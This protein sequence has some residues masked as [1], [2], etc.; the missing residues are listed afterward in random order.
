MSLS[1]AKYVLAVVGLAIFLGSLLVCAHTA[2]Y[3]GRAARA[4]GT[5]TALVRRQNTA[6]TN[7][8]G[9]ISNGP[10]FTYSWQAVVRFR[11]DGQQTEFDDSVATNPPAYHVGETVNVLYLESNPFDARI[12]SFTS[13]WLVPMIFGGI[14]ILLLVVACAMF[15]R[16]G[17]ADSSV[18]ASS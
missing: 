5:V 10:P 9:S 16:S 17:P 11:H 8:N 7:T 4:Q 14:G 15:F 2:S 3:I 13:L 1:T 6:D 12:Y 18:T